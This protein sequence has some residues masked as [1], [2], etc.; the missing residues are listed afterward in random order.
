[1]ASFRFGEGA[2]ERTPAS[3]V[4]PKEES[5]TGGGRVVG[6]EEV[7]IRSADRF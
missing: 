7:G 3:G 6:G 5:G 2:G 1:M 4:L